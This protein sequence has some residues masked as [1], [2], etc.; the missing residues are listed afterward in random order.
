[1]LGARQIQPVEGAAGHQQ[2]LGRIQTARD[3]DD[4]LLRPRRLHPPHQALDL[5]VE[6]LETVLVQPR[7]IVGHEGEA[8]QRADQVGRLDVFARLEGHHGRGLALQSR[9]VREG[10]VAQPVQSDP[11]HVDVGDGQMAVEGEPLALGQ[12]GAQ[13]VDRRLPVPGQVGGAL[14]P[15][16][17]REDIGRLGPRRLAGAQHGPL[18]RLADHDVGGRQ[19][20][21]DP[22]PGQRRPRRGR[23]GGPEVLADLDGE[24]EAGPVD[25][26]E[27]QA[28]REVDRLAV[29]QDRVLG[30]AGGRGE[31]AFLVIFPV[32]GQIGLGHD[33]Q[34]LARRP[35]RRR[36]LNRA[37]P[38]AQRR[39]DHGDQP[40]LRPPPRP[41]RR[42]GARPR[43][44]G[45]PA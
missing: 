43:P 10:A 45:R 12:S 20:Q 42:S 3:A 16:G 28:G 41:G 2:G 33:T 13:F 38:T 40:G 21:Q 7:R 11:V 14:A 30:R 31:P 18:V 1:M 15:A 5:D 29:Q 35:A 22:R 24:D 44:A 27:D 9:A 23:Q 36:Q 4:Q 39:A 19:V 34:H 32:V 37:S 8:V 6:G 25:R 17:G 26:L